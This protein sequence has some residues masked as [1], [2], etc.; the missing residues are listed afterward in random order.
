MNV[1]AA[2]LR[3]YAESTKAG[4]DLGTTSITY[5]GPNGE[6]EIVPHRFVK[7]GEAFLLDLSSWS[8]VGSMDVTTACPVCRRTSSCSFRVTPV[9]S[10]RNFSD[11]APFCWNPSAQ[12]YISGIVNNSL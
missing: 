10:F 11:Q 7:A 12:T 8:R 1:D 2:A 9:S 6:I 4:L 5:Y 3:R